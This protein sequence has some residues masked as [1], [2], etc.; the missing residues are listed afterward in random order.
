MQVHTN[1][2]SFQRNGI[3]SQKNWNEWKLKPPRDSMVNPSVSFLNEY[4]GVLTSFIASCSSASVGFCPSDLIT[5][6][7][8]QIHLLIYSFI[9]LFIYSLSHLFIYSFIHLSITLF[10]YLTLVLI[11]PLPSLSNLLKAS[12][13]T[14]FS[15]V[16]S[17]A[18]ISQKR[19]R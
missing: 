5:R 12:L 7:S 1:T 14:S 9:H 17:T 6:A 11:F 2:R 15:S 10:I 4:S 18:N 13:K 8:S 16:E 3:Y 19:N